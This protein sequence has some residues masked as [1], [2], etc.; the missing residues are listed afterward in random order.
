MRSFFSHLLLKPI[1]IAK[2]LKVKTLT[3]I[4][5][6]FTWSWLL[7]TETERHLLKN[8][9]KGMNRINPSISIIVI[10]HNPSRFSWLIEC[11]ETLQSQIYG[12]FEIVVITNYELPSN[13]NRSLKELKVANVYF[14]KNSHPSQA[15]NFGIGKCKSQLVMF[16]DDDNLL[17]P[18]HVLFMVQ[19]YHSDPEASIFLGSYMCFQNE[20]VTDFPLRYAVNR[21]TLVIGDPSDVSS[22]AM[23]KSSFPAI[24]WDD[25]VMSE[26][27]AFL[28]DA[29]D[30]NFK[31]HQISAPLSLHRNH[32]NSRTEMIQRPLV[33]K[34]W[35]NKYRNQIDWGFVVPDS[36]RKAKILKV[37][38]ALRMT[39][40]S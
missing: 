33:P 39:L 30:M 12:E 28:I 25:E 20:T 38:F 17:L 7:F 15:R 13:L 4:P 1:L 24:H 10:H 21:R 19:A 11:I 29:L 36:T 9:F 22:I 3:S 5:M 35:F 8:G 31:V 14:F 18:W 40:D 27:W 37:I 32:F 6:N 16:I 26:N 34:D 2:I 23:K